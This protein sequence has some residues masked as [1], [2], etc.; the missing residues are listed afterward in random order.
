MEY[1]PVASIAPSEVIF[2]NPVAWPE[3]GA[4]VERVQK[5]E[6]AHIYQ[7]AARRATEDAA[8]LPAKPEAV[9]VAGLGEGAS[10]RALQLWNEFTYTAWRRGH[11]TV[12]QTRQTRIAAAIRD[13]DLFREAIATELLEGRE[14]DVLDALHQYNVL[15]TLVE[16]AKHPRVLLRTVGRVDYMG[17][18]DRDL[19]DLVAR[20][21]Q[22]AH[23][24]DASGR[25]QA[26]GR[27]VCDAQYVGTRFPIC[28]ARGA[29]NTRRSADSSD[30]IG[31]SA[32]AISSTYI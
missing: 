27:N 21:D 9:P 24:P 11:L 31:C 14:I 23:S 20:Q 15:T 18:A 30:L 10:K 3:V 1:P 8:Q 7:H 28:A 25:P 19:H 12:E 6:T 26:F 32:G 16:D 22:F 17:V 5:D 4:V 29:R 2:G 13:A